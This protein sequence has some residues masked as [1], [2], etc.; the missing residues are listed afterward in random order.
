MSSLSPYQTSTVLEQAF[1]HPARNLTKSRGK[2]I[3]RY[4][5]VK[6]KNT[7]S[8]E[9]MLEFDACFH[10]DFNREV[11]RFCSQPI[12]FS[13]ELE[14]KIHTYVPDFVAQF[15]CGEF[16]LYEVKANEFTSS[17]LFKSEFEGKKTAAHQLLGID[18]ELIEEKTIRTRPLL[19]NLKRIHRYSSRTQLS[20]NQKRII[21]ILHKHGSQRVE[22]L[23]ARTGLTRQTILPII[24]DLLSRCVL[25]AD[26]YI[27]LSKNTE[28]GLA[29]A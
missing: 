7:I 23:M 17:E 28:L 9:S 15:D 10:F 21:E 4:T 12:R 26:L 19:G 22:S 18:L 29:Y 25:Q 11:V 24:C 8:V 6:M 2:N 1:I 20:D 27:P 13:Y 3:H 14:G 16:V 5:S